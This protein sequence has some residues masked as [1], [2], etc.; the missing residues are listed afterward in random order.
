M[1]PISRGISLLAAA[2]QFPLAPEWPRGHGRQR[3][4]SLTATQPSRSCLCVS[5]TVAATVSCMEKE[6]EW[7]TTSE[8]AQMARMS[9]ATL[10]RY[11]A[12]DM[13]PR[14]VQRGSR[15]LVRSDWLTDWLLS[16]EAA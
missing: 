6:K 12:L 4:R 7:L 11:W 3:F 13:G 10:Y 14:Y 15:R 9:R 2:R 8:A 16:Q 5:Q 1:G